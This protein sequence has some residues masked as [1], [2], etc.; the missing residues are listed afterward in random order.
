MARKSHIPNAKYDSEDT[1]LRIGDFEISCYVLDNGQR[2]LSQSGMIKA[3]GM[4][5]GG[6]N[7]KLGG[8]RLAK[9]IDG[10]RIGS[11]VS[12]DLKAGI[13]NPIQFITKNKNEAFGYDA[14]LL[15][16]LIRSLSKAYLRGDL[17]KQQDHIGINAE[18]LDDAFSKVGLIAL[19]DEATGY[20]KAK[21]R[22]KDELQKF[23]D[24]VLKDKAVKWVKTFRDDFFEMIF[25]M[26]G[27]GWTT[28]AKKPSVV[29][30]YI[31]DLV[32]S[33]VGPNV[34]AELRKRNPKKTG[35]QGREKKH[36]QYLTR[37]I[38]HPMLKDHIAGL[39]ALG[40]ASGFDWEIFKKMVDKVYPKFGQTIEINFPENFER[41]PDKMANFNKKLKKGLD[42]NPN[43]N[44]S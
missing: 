22:A 34:L 42:W 37:D 1:P 23:L 35:T 21:G 39:I 36:H 10:K 30:H 5:S 3:L 15:Q 4:Q 13:K 24:S 31:N 38:G 19:V 33:R 20:D 25:R 29:G 9:F 18:M 8:D 28:T 12:R 44:K 43:E 26:K 16:E 11:L 41:P 32:Y 7:K 2:V 40:T 14:L 6:A 17:Q 27:W